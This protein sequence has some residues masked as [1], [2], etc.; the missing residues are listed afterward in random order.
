MST[1]EPVPAH[2]DEFLSATAAATVATTPTASSI[3]PV[4]ATGATTTAAAVAAAAAAAAI[5]GV[6]LD[7]G[8]VHGDAVASPHATLLS[9]ST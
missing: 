8:F 3:F 9:P 5:A 1:G 7:V 6:I 2:V 4:A